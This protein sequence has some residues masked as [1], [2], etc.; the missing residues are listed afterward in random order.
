MV[1]GVTGRHVD[2]TI[3]NGEVIME[4]RKLINIDEEKIMARSRELAA[5]V[6]KRF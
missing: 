1:F 4:G 2:T 3:I 6:W 5:A